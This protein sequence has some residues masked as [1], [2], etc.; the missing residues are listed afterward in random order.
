MVWNLKYLRNGSNVNISKPKA[1]QEIEKNAHG[2]SEIAKK[3]CE[4]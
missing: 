3:M 4:S 2:E 1:L